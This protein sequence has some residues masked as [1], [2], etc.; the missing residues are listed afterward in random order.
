MRVCFETNVPF[1]LF[2]FLV[3]FFSFVF[4]F[5]V[6]YSVCTCAGKCSEQRSNYTWTEHNNLLCVLQ[7]SI[8]KGAERRRETTCPPGGGW[9]TN[10]MFTIPK[11]PMKMLLIWILPK[12]L[13]LNSF[14]NLQ[15]IPASVIIARKALLKSPQ[16]LRNFDLMF[17]LYLSTHHI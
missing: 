4:S 8:L 13:N 14:V 3:L 6:V 1:V 15:W 10:E 16:S 12:H 7:W 9:L 11:Y 5:V 17:T 2:L